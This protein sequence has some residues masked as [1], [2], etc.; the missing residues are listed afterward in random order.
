[1][2]TNEEAIADQLAD[3][4]PCEVAIGGGEY[5]SMEDRG[6]AQHWSV[7]TDPQEDPP[8]QQGK[9]RKGRRGKTTSP[10]V[11]RSSPYARHDPAMEISEDE[12][13][14]VLPVPGQPELSPTQVMGPP[15][16]EHP[17]PVWQAMEDNDEKK[18]RVDQGHDSAEAQGPEDCWY[19]AGD[20]NHWG[21]YHQQEH[22]EGAQVP[23]RRG[24]TEDEAEE[25]SEETEKDEKEA[26]DS[27]AEASASEMDNDG[28]SCSDMTATRE[29]RPLTA[30][31]SSSRGVGRKVLPLPDR[32]LLRWPRS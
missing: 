19:D 24:E 29:F 27:H 26:A 14:T 7:A 2:L 16:T 21:W 31:R 10:T 1:M 4:D 17:D 12:L 5:P 9:T 23:S 28:E 32:S 15:A 11:N 22:A 20:A 13:A 18:R 6:Q 25:E 30:Q 3:V 8:P